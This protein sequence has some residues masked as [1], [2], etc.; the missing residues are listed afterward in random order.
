MW[1]QS[2]PAPCRVSSPSFVRQNDCVLSCDARRIPSARETPQHAGPLVESLRHNSPQI[3]DEHA[4]APSGQRRR[5]SASRRPLSS[6]PF[7]ERVMASGEKPL[8]Q[9]LFARFGEDAELLL[10]L[11]RAREAP[12]GGEPSAE[13]HAQDKR[14]Q[15]AR[16]LSARR[17]R[18]TDER[19]L[20]G[21]ERVLGCER[22]RTERRRNAPKSGDYARERSCRRRARRAA[23]PKGFRAFG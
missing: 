8:H 4:E 5:T 3:V 12:L 16:D 10:G 21:R 15:H 23:P 20:G 22:T 14:S 11:T 2:S 17:E 19:G 18:K 7:V 1:G 6:Y 9:R 13:P